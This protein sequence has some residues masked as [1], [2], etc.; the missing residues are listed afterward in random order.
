[1]PTTALGA[2][3]SV[4]KS[5][6]AIPHVL[7]P[8]DASVAC[9]PRHDA[10]ERRKR[11]GTENIPAIV[12]LSIALDLLN[13]NGPEAYI[14]MREL[15]N[16]FESKI[17][18]EL[19]DVLIN[20]E[21]QRICN[22]SNLDFLG[23]HGEDLLRLLDIEGISSSHGAACATGAV[24]PSRILL[25]MG[26]SR[27]RALSSLRFSLSRVTKEDEIDEAIKIVVKTVNK[28]RSLA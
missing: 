9:D 6:L 1:M 7:L 28:L 25:N 2:G 5:C 8:R 23:I 3:F 21:A 13:I 18:S 17:T 10:Q 11:A 12:G 14:R 26:F 27:K 24:E 4:Y 22:T 15:R 16:H 20:G 19:K